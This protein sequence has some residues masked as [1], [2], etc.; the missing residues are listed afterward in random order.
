MTNP[1]AGNQ[2]AHRG[3]VIALFPEQAHGLFQGNLGQVDPEVA[4]RMAES[5][6]ESA[7]AFCRALTRAKEKGEVR[8]DLDPAAGADVLTSTKMAMSLM[9]RANVDLERIMAFGRNALATVI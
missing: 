8:A 2:V 3:I 7:A 5:L 6:E 9:L 1:R 4:A